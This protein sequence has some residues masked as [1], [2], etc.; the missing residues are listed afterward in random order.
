MNMVRSMLINSSLFVSL[1][2]YAFGTTKY[3]LNRVPGKSVLKTSFEL[4]KVRKPSL[5]HLHVRCY[6]AKVRIYNPHEQK[7]DSRTTNGVFIG[8]PE[9]SKGC[10][11][12]CQSHSM[13]ILE[14]KS[15]RFIKNDVISGSM[16]PR[17]VEIR[18]VS[19]EIPSSITSS[20]VVHVVV[21]SVNNPQ[22]E[23]IN[24]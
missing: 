10:R 2:M 14:T 12:Y 17:K 6:Q 13:R 1:W 11:F 5:R 22:E 4:W 3:L 7:L 8:Y 18:E 20:Q 24:G 23:Q 21:D 9:K 15:V 19:M 16:E